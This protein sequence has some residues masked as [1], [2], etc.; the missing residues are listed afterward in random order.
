VHRPQ[1]IPEGDI[2]CFLSCG[3]IVRQEELSG[4]R[5]NLV[6]HESPLPMG[7]GWPPLTWQILKG[8]NQVPV[9]L[10]EAANKV[11]SG[12]IYLQEVLEFNGHELI[13][14]IRKA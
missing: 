7:K 10:F 11:D 8:T 13:D 5:H 4:N 14:K 9:V 2:C 3:Q 6:V 12:A 1:Q